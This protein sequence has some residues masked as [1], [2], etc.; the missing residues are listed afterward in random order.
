MLAH[1][2][3]P[4]REKAI[5]GRIAELAT[6]VTHILS[7]KNDTAKTL[8]EAVQRLVKWINVGIAA[9]TAT[10]AIFAGFKGIL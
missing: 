10:G 9:A 5:G 1:A 3:Q 8:E 4:L 6:Y 2:A 7:G